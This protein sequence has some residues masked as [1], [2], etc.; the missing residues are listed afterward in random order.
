[1]SIGPWQI[2]LIIAIV[3]IF[4]GP[5]RLPGLGKSIGEAIRG[6]KKGLDG[7]GNGEIDVTDSAKKEELKSQ[8]S[9]ESE[10]SNQG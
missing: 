7:A 6:F 9:K 10:P 3:L 4:F 1:M 8:T 5:S 2:I